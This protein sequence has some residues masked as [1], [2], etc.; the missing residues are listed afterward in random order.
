MIFYG[1]PG[2]GKTYVAKEIAAEYARSGGGFEIVQFH[3][4]YSYEDFVEGCPARPQRQRAA[5]LH[6]HAGAAAAHRGRGWRRTRT[7]PTCS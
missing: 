7:A 5:G 1:P 2:T 3:P 4:S 6:A